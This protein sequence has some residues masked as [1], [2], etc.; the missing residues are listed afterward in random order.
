MSIISINLVFN[1]L[2]VILYETKLLYFQCI[3]IDLVETL[4]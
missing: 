1:D 2:F 4:R 3:E